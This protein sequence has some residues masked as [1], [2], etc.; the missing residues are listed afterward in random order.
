MQPTVFEFGAGY[1]SP[2]VKQAILEEIAVTAEVVRLTRQRQ[3][4]F[5]A[6]SVCSICGT[7]LLP[8]DENH[9]VSSLN[10]MRDGYRDYCAAH[11][12]AC[13][14]DEEDD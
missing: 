7:P 4:M 3:E 8:Y 1:D 6:A 14:H 9:H 10:P 13:Q 5:A 11:C 12:P 2:E